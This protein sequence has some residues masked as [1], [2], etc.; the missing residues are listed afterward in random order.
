[1]VIIKYWQEYNTRICFF[2][3][4]APFQGEL[5][6]VSGGDGAVPCP[7]NGTTSGPTGFLTRVEWLRWPWFPGPFL[8]RGR[9]GP[10]LTWGSCWIASG[11]AGVCASEKE[12]FHVHSTR[13]CGERTM[14]YRSV[15]A[16]RSLIGQHY[17][18]H[19]RG[20]I[21]VVC[22]A[23]FHEG[24]GVFVASQ[25]HRRAWVILLKNWRENNNVFNQTTNTYL[26]YANR[27][28]FH[29]HCHHYWS[30]RHLEAR[31]PKILHSHLC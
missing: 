29:N 19:H 6:L 5:L 24:D 8:R 23:L 20:E 2:F 17:Q 31:I 16:Q 15:T 21:L 14:T 3:N 12:I 7:P 18:C 22:P 13:S 26:I 25:G 9:P 1:M 30:R 11:A 27:L 28:H 4:F 10:L